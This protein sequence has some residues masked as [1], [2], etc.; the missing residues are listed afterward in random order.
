MLHSL[1]QPAAEP[2]TLRPALGDGPV[3]PMP[4]NPLGSATSLCTIGG[5]GGSASSK[6][7][8]E[9]A[10]HDGWLTDGLTQPYGPL[11]RDTSGLPRSLSVRPS[12]SPD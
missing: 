11:E 2:M 7:G 4:A 12:T 8:S 5:A 6:N 3:S 1:A 9:V 10:V